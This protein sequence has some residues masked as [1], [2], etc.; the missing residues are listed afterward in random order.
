MSDIA[1]TAPAQA[2]NDDAA[3]EKAPDPR[4]HYSSPEDL[5]EDI[6]LDIATREELLRQ[7]KKDLD[8]RLEAEAEGMSASD[9]ISQ[10]KE[11][12]LAS[13]HRRVSKALEEITSERQA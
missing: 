2:V 3:A 10:E 8:Q 1:E 4:R 12:R 11:S 5:R 13:E 9:P 7:W 6:D